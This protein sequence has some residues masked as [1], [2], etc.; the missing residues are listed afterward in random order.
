MH[1]AVYYTWVHTSKIDFE[2]CIFK[3]ILYLIHKKI[4]FRHTWVHF[5]C[6]V[7][8]HYVIE[9]KYHLS[10]ILRCTYENRPV[11]SPKR[12]WNPTS[13]HAENVYRN[14]HGVFEQSLLL[15][16]EGSFSCS[17]HQLVLA[18]EFHYL[19]LMSKISEQ[20]CVMQ[21]FCVRDSLIS[22]YK[23]KTDISHLSTK[24]LKHRI[25]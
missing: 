3:L 9:L 16:S 25:R 20:V 8:I 19:I 10:V 12:T 24:T 13:V 21:F 15:S 23:T 18:A 14:K 1:S 2:C 22:S 11:T 5:K 17:P 6:T 4:V 7:L